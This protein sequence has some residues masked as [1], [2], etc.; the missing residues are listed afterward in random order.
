MALPIRWTRYA[1]PTRHTAYRKSRYAIL[2]QITAPNP[3]VFNTVN[4]SGVP[5]NSNF[6]ID[7]PFTPGQAVWAHFLTGASGDRPSWI[8]NDTSTSLWPLANVETGLQGDSGGPNLKMWSI[9]IPI[10]V[11]GVQIP[12]TASLR[13]WR[14]GAVN[15]ARGPAGSNLASPQTPAVGGTQAY[16]IGACI[17]VS[18]NIAVMPTSDMGLIIS[19]Q[20]AIIGAMAHGGTQTFNITVAA[21]HLLGYTLWVTDSRPPVV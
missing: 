21:T 19:G 18:P 10:N 6:P 15:A 9:T 11:V 2:A 12:A 8:L 16:L 17:G 1:T 4:T 20:S 13:L 7:S 5:S 3:D 14:M